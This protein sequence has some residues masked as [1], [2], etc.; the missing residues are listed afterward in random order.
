MRTGLIALVLTASCIVVRTKAQYPDLDR[1]KT[2]AAGTV[3]FHYHCNDWQGFTQGCQFEAEKMKMEVPPWMVPGSWHS[4][5]MVDGKGSYICSSPADLVVNSDLDIRNDG[6]G[7][8]NTS[9]NSLNRSYSGCVSKGQDWSRVYY[10]IYSA[11][12]F[13][14]PTQGPVTLG[15][16]HG[17]NKDVCDG[18]SDC[19]STINTDPTNVCPFK[20]DFWPRYNSFVCASWTPNV[21]TT[22]WGQQYFSND[23]GPITWPSTGYLQPDGIKATTGVNHPSSIQY[24]GYVYVFYHDAG[25]YGGLNGHS[26]E[27]RQEGIKV[28]RAP[29]SEALNPYAYEAYY[30]D[31]SGNEYWNPSLPEGFTR[32]KLLDYLRVQ[33]PMSTDLMGDE[34]ANRY[35]NLRFSVAR[36]R[37]KDYFI[38]V[39]SY[40]DYADGKKYKTALRFSTD[41][42]HWTDRRMIVDVATD[43]TAS[44]MNYPIFLSSDGWSNSVV[45]END[46]YIL[47]TASTI[48]NRVYKKH[49]SLSAAGFSTQALA[50][51]TSPVVAGGSGA[52]EVMS[53]SPN[54]GPGLLQISYAVGDY[55]IVRVNVFDLTGRRLVQGTPMQRA[56]GAYTERVDLSG[57]AGGVYLLELMTGKERK[58]IKVMKE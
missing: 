57:F 35:G 18:G 34:G 25:P 15:F 9:M 40:I 5:F 20:G 46:F 41:L 38:G 53:V 1:Y 51:R 44:T 4:Y 12:Y 17:E 58:V 43:F 39:E 13:Q 26:E 10:A 42:L 11:E 14:H 19:H 32:E 52:L 16:L 23:M 27:G 3:T 47:G 56:P 50:I 8:F 31:P 22:N 7:P 21:R 48:T 54:P 30:R 6:V 37:D 28:V 55:S 2:S 49:I 36:V 29:L 45:D 33:G 24:N